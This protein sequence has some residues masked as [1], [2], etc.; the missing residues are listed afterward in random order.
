MLGAI[1][2]P[3]PFAALPVI[4]VLIGGVFG[5]QSND[6][7]VTRDAPTTIIEDRVLTGGY[8]QPADL[9][10]VST[11]SQPDSLGC[12]DYDLRSES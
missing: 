12:E 5:P 1:L 9:A 11:S 2:L 3:L 6:Q 4:V 7:L 8:E 10:K